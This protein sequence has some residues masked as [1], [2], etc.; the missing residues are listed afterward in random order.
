MKKYMTPDFD[1]TAYENKETITAMDGDEMT[2]LAEGGWMGDLV[3]GEKL[4]KNNLI[5]RGLNPSGVL[6]F[7]FLLQ[8]CK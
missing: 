1:V 2:S 8:N 7:H 5:P 3:P 6:F 4:I